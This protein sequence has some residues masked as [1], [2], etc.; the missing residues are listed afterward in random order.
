MLLVV[1]DHPQPAAVLLPLVI[2]VI[3]IKNHNKYSK[4]N[5]IIINNIIITI[6]LT[7][8]SP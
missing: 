7:F 1:G 5:N 3:L 4:I 2:W 8:F 6:L